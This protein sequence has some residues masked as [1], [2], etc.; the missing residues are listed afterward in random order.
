[1]ITGF[2]NNVVSALAE[3]VTSIQTTITV[4]PDQ[5]AMFAA[6]LTADF[7]NPSNPQNM[8][9]IITLTNSGQ[10]AR[11]IC[12][13]TAVKGDVLT[14]VRGREGTTARGWSLNDVVAN[15]ATRGSENGFVQAEQLQTGQ[16]TAAVAGGSENVLA[17]Q[18]PGTFFLNNATDWTFR[19]PIIVVPTLTNT[20]AATLQLVIGGKVLGTFPL[21]KGNK[22]ELEAGDII[23]D[24]PIACLLD[25]SKT[26]FSVINPV[27]VYSLDKGLVRSVN[28]IL[29]NDKGAVTLKPEDVSA[30]QQGGG[31]GMKDNKVYLGWSGTK[32]IAQVDSTQM[33]ALFY[34]KNPPT[35]AQTGAY[36]LSGGEVEGEVW[37]AVDN[38]YRLVAGNRG[39]FWRF[40]SSNMYLM[41]TND[42]DPH[43][44][45]NDLRPL[46][47][48]FATGKL[49]TG[50]DFSAGGNVYSGGGAS[51]LATDGNIY[52]SVWGGFL[53][54]WIAGQISAQVGAVQTWVSQ[55]FV[56]SS[57]Q[58]S[59]TWS[60]KVGGG[61]GLQVPAGCVVIGAR[62]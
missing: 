60:G 4:M 7:E 61:A 46:I 9:A 27:K 19:T 42:G 45:F 15:F 24:I 55:N 36:P 26:F 43:G 31:T 56:N 11:E 5:G 10:T 39:A 21:Y 41:F 52:G 50:H 1:M 2:G 8:Y 38:N 54:N 49:S 29:P 53:N 58:A 44:G 13:L 57:R 30:V 17:I 25:K 22:A 16:Y 40:D 37:S 35:A 48:D 33:G 3:N 20:G 34:E 18:L 47:A 51:R 12:H 28:K 14:V 6:L 59:A 23:A 62:N 32:L